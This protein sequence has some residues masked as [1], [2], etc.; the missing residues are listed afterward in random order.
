MLNPL[1]DTNQFEVNIYY[2]IFTVLS[3][4]CCVLSFSNM[5]WIV[6]GLVIHFIRNTLPMLDPE[7]RRKVMSNEEWM[8]LCI[9]QT[10]AG[11]IYIMLINNSTDKGSFVITG[12]LCLILFAAIV[13]CTYGF[14]ANS[15]W[16]NQ[17]PGMTIGLFINIV[18]LNI[19]KKIHKDAFI[20]IREKVAS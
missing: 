6:P 8:S 19:Q 2:W 9:F 20:E 11:I 12:S 3:A 5:K 1:E 10:I 17:M 16:I 14:E 13:S 4:T 7:D 15:A 18:F